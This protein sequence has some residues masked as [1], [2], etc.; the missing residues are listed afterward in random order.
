MGSF[1]VR[2]GLEIRNHAMRKRFAPLLL[3]PLA[4]CA[5][6]LGIVSDCSGSMTSVRRA[7]GGPP[8]STQ[9]PTE[10]DGDFEEVWFYFTSGSSTGRKYSFRWGESLL[11]CETDGPIPV[12][13]VMIGNGASTL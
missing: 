3:L 10:L 7:E 5:D 2:V 6:A 13:R 4:G 11:T 9:G 8:T 1:P 12:S